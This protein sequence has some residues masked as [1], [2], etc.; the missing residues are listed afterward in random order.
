MTDIAK[1]L[2]DKIKND[3]LFKKHPFVFVGGTA[4]S[5]HIQH[6]VSEDLDFAFTADIPIYDVRAFALRHNGIYL[7]DPAASAFRINTGID[8]DSKHMKFLIDDVKVEF[9]YPADPLSQV[10]LSGEK[11]YFNDSAIQILNL[12]DIAKMK[13][14]A[15]MD[16]IKIRDIFDVDEIL[17]RDILSADE[18]FV[19]AKE[20]I[21]KDEIAVLEKIK[22]MKEEKSDESLYFADGSDVPSF[23]ELKINLYNRLDSHL[24]NDLAES[25]KKTI[26]SLIGN[27]G[28]SLEDAIF[29]I[30]KMNNTASV[31]MPC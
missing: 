5:H 23:D 18:F 8:L 2:L 6:R 14:K 22:V 9:F 25:E 17:K 13:I 20:Y 15:L 1:N 29:K 28:G 27:T 7:S 11:N 24:R 19:V 21:K 10:C 31:E 30:N 16:R 26:E 12:K 4:L 3:E